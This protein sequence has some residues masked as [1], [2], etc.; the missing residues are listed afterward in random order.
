[1]FR[2][3]CAQFQHVVQSLNDIVVATHAVGHTV[4]GNVPPPAGDKGNLYRCIEQI[5]G[6]GAVAL[7]TNAVMPHIHSVVGG[8]YNQRVLGNTLFSSLSSSFPTPASIAVT[9]A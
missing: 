4:F 5:E 3:L 9:A 6:E 2:K 7:S 8:E 1:M